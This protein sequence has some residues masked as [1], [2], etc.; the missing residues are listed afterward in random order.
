VPAPPALQIEGLSKRYGHVHALRDV[1]FEV[2]P[3]EVFGYLGPNGA[4]KSTTLRILLGLVRPG[5][6]RAR[7]L[8]QPAGRA[9]SRERVGFLPGDLRLPAGMTGR[10]VLDHFARFRPQHPPVLRGRLLDALDLKDSDLGR[11]VKWLSHGTRQ[12]IG[13]VVAMQHD[14]DL[15]LLDEPST[16]LD[17][18]VQRGLREVVRELAARGRAVLFSSHVLSEVEAVCGRVAVLRDGAL[19]AVESIE[20]L[21]GRLVRRLEARF[22]GAA[23]ADLGALPGVTRAEIAGATATLWLRGDVNPLLRRLAACEVEHLVFPEPQL[24]DVFLD[25]YRGAETR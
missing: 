23:P 9:A 8:G 12:K 25:L 4:G 5:H 20:S 1:S 24:E 6:G 16:G 11:R 15:V 10:A 14:P 13:L 21:R 3:G 22:R 7:L 18:L 17:P 2:A 19:L